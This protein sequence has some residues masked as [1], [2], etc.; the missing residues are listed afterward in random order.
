MISTNNNAD[1]IYQ[2][3]QP[4]S[5]RIANSGPICPFARGSDRAVSVFG[6]RCDCPEFRSETK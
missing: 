1:T 2:S 5:A 4:M 6:V 3:G